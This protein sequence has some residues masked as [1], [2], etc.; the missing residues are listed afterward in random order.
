MTES[1]KRTGE[2]LANLLP[3]LSEQDRFYLVAYGEGMAN[4]AER[5]SQEAGSTPSG[6]RHEKSRPAGRREGGKLE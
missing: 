2:R 5:M 4:K 3:R 1:D 6:P